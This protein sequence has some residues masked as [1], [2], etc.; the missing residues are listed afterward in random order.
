MPIPAATT[1][2][3]SSGAKSSAAPT[4]CQLLMTV[5]LPVRQIGVASSVATREV[6]YTT[7]LLL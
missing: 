7:R 2:L 6:S 3:G 5:V 1:P 4:S